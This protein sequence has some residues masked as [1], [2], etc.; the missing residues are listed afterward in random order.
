MMVVAIGHGGNLH[1]SVTY[2]GV[3]IGTVDLP[4]RRTWSGG[5]LVPLPAFERVRPLL[6]AVADLGPAAVE[7]LLFLAADKAVDDSL[8]IAAGAAL[9]FGLAD[10]TG[11]EVPVGVVRVVIT[12]ADLQPRVLADFRL[13]ACGVPARPPRRVRRDGDASDL[14]A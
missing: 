6:V 1:Y 7:R 4:D 10:P 5:A 9:R 14:G 13:D 8:V 2:E 12:G 3:P 11:Q